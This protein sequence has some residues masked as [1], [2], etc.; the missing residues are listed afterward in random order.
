MIRAARF[1]DIPALT[2]LMQEGH[3]R[4]KYFGRA[5]VDPKEARGLLMTCV[6]GEGGTMVMVSD[7]AD[8][9]PAGFM[10][11]ILE[12]V[13]HVADRLATSDL[14]LYVSDRAPRFAWLEL[15][16]AYDEWARANPKVIQVNVSATDIVG[17]YRRVERLY[18]RL[19]FRQSGVI[20]ERAVA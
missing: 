5:G 13:Y 3:A 20:Y 15:L 9:K 18:R 14:Y 8:G 17:D 2:A 1:A 12:R 16:L 10:V 6:Q 7:D 19:G 11:G 4:S